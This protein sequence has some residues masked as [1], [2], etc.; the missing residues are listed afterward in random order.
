MQLDVTDLI[1]HRPPMVLVESLIEMDEDRGI[2]RCMCVLPAGSPVAAAGRFPRMLVIEMLAQTAACLKGYIELKHGLPIRPA[3]LVRIDDLE[4]VRIPEQGE[5]IEVE[6][7][8]E[9]SLGGY[10]V[11]EAHCTA[12]GDRIAGGTLRF[13]VEGG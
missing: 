11:Y 8:Q 4:I 7:R 2:A 5:R 12:C 9:R 6:A 10:F 13:V 3:Y 1:P